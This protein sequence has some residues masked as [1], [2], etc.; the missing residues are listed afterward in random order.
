MRRQL[1]LT[2][3]LAIP[4]LSNAQTSD[5][6][7]MDRISHFKPVHKGEYVASLSASFG[8]FSSNNSEQLL[9][10][11]NIDASGSMTSIKPSFGYFYSDR[12]M[13]GARFSYTDIDGSISSA[14]L[15]LGSVN[16]LVFDIPSF[17]VASSSYACGVFHRSYTKLDR[18]GQFELFSEIELMGS[19]TNYTIEQSLTGNNALIENKISRASISFNPGLAVN[20]TP[21]VATFISF[22][23]G[24]LSYSTVN[25]YD[26]DGKFLGKRSSSKMNLSIDIFDINFGM[27]IHLWKNR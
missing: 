18:K 21:N 6:L 2:L 20:I 14:T 4:F 19:R 11:E 22:G 12:S 15:D 17:S 23:L 13:V 3:L 7:V 1:L 8:G 5:S 27:S 24:G 9:L 10:L 16:D 26:A 25:Q